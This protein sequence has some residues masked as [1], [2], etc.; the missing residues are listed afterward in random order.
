MSNADNN[1]IWKL[2]KGYIAAYTEDKGL[3]QR[4]RRASTRGWLIMAE[5]YDLKTEKKPRIA[6][7]YKI[8]IEDRRQAERVFK[9]EMRE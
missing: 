4:I 1:E 7:Q 5:Y 9:V 8:P 3:M 2:E 6:V